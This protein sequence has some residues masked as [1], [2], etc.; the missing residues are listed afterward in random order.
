MNITVALEFVDAINHAEIDKIWSLMSDDHLFI[1]SQE[2]KFVGKDNMKQGWIGYFA[3]F[4][5]YKIEIV[6][7]LEKDTLVC[8]FGYAS[9]TYKNLKDENNSN[10]WKIPA[11]WRAIIKDNK[12]EQWQV[13]ADNIVVIDIINKN[14]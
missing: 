5:D 7:T 13:Y 2:N 1:D 11:A 14:K 12:V 4:P 3:L 6:E 8:M 9:G 10:F